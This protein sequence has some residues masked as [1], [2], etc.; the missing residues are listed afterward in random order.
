MIKI[1]NKLFLFN[2]CK[3]S[4]I[5]FEYVPNIYLKNKTIKMWILARLS[6]DLNPSHFLVA[7]VKRGTVFCFQLC[8]DLFLIF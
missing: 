8:F 1:S 4:E 3:V 5:L 7:T 6:F 2:L